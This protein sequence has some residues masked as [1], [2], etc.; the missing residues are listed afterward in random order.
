[1]ILKNVYI[2]ISA[3]LPV[4]ALFPMQDELVAALPE[5]YPVFLKSDRFWC[6]IWN[7]NMCH[8]SRNKRMRACVCV[9]G[10]KY[11]KKMRCKCEIESRMNRVLAE[12][13]SIA[14]IQRIRFRFYFFSFLFT[15]SQWTYHI[16]ERMMYIHH[17]TGK[18]NMLPILI[19]RISVVGR[20]GRQIDQVGMWASFEL[21]RLTDA[22]QFQNSITNVKRMTF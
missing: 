12:W 5:K 15:L 13:F 19:V 4:P 22:N 2:R 3:I 6:L 10:S 11:N 21:A 16:S 20:M 18:S 17:L 14:W 1:M 8:I 7:V 9:H